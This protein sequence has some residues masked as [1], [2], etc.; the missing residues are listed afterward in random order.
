REVPIRQ[1]V[2][3]ILSGLP[4][5]RE[6]RVWPSSDIRSAFETAVKTGKIDDFHFHDTRHPFASWFVMRG[7]NPQSLVVLLGQRRLAM[8]MRYAHLAPK[9]LRD[10]MAKT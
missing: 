7:V 8:T 6:G 4:G 9:H 5:P 3:N 1:I 10:E 2:Y